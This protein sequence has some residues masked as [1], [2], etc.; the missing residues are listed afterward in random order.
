MSLNVAAWPINYISTERLHKTN[1]HFT[2]R[3]N[4]DAQQIT[5]F[6]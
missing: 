3:V 6:K 1:F 2:Y 5:A 4:I